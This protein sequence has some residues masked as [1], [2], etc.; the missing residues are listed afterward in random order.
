[1]MRLRALRVADFGRFSEPA[2]VEAFGD[3]LNI[4][5]G[6][7]ELG[8]S[9]LVAALKAV[10]HAGFGSKT[11]DLRKLVPNDGGAPL[12]EADFEAEGHAWR[13]RKRFLKGAFAHLTDLQSG[14]ILRN[15]DAQAKL[16]ALLAGPPE[17]ERFGFLWVEQGD[18]L[19]DIADNAVGRGLSG[20]LDTEIDSVVLDTRARAT[21]KAIKAALKPL[22]TEKSSKPATGGAWALAI[23]AVT[24]AEKQLDSATQRRSEQ[25][26]RLDDLAKAHAE[27]AAL[28][29]PAAATGR[30]D[31]IAQARLRL[32]KAQEAL[33]QRSLTY[34]QLELARS[35]LQAAERVSTALAGDLALLARI[36]S[37]QVTV[38]KKIELISQRLAQVAAARAAADAAMSTHVI[39][40]GR[41]EEDMSTAK[42]RAAAQEAANIRDQLAERIN[43]ARQAEIEGAAAAERSARLSAVTA[44]R[45]AQLRQLEIALAEYEAAFA[46]VVPEVRI[47]LLAGRTAAVR[48]HGQS[49]QANT[50]LHP[51]APLVIEIEGVGHIRIA[52]N[53]ASVTAERHAARAKLRQDA[54]DLRRTLG[55][56]TLPDADVALAQRQADDAIAREAKARLSA[57]APGGVEAL[58]AQHADAASRAICHEPDGP[59]VADV[60]AA[61]TTERA[62]HATSTDALRKVDHNA[63]TAATDL[64]RL[65]AAAA[66]NAEQRARLT[67]QLG[68][69]ATHETLRLT[70]ETDLAH[71]RTAFTDAQSAADAWAKYPD[72]DRVNEINADRVS[73]ERAMADIDARAASLDRSIAALEGALRAAGDDDIEGVYARALAARTTALRRRSEIEIEVQALTLLE[74]SFDALAAAGQSELS[75]P[76]RARIAPYMDLVFP[77]AVLQFGNGLAP[78]QLTRG[79]R[80][81]AHTQLSRGTREQIAILVRLGLA[82]LLADRGAGVPL[83]L[84]DALVYADDARLTHMFDALTRAAQTSQVILLTCRTQ[85]FANLVQRPGATVLSMTPWKPVAL[86]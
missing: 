25:Q 67:Q 84:D 11:D 10:F 79:T 7:N 2:A 48:I 38:T 49:L 39:S 43:N 78:A 5:T 18:T 61:I 6:P 76:V 60:A 13:I 73:K 54:D 56:L 33:Q 55:V 65:E 66:A 40:L 35:K 16:T 37:E 70:A 74:T 29:E 50:V 12:V 24:E 20:L 17:L 81:E 69:G 72:A 30:A 27:R 32:A 22:R 46:A 71:A 23:A 57:L 80:A 15:A 64:A 63:A 68:D 75:A 21:Q 59:S 51:D 58:V 77:E 19:E 34:G 42:S 14:A 83:L 86:V 1:M 44:P 4:L 36:A 85:A 28:L 62:A 3:T 8:K 82:R 52:P 47:E 31:A 45:I 53:P 41:L 26:S 9:T